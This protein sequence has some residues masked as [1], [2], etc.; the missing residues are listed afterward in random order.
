MS[1][2][3]LCSIVSFTFIKLHFQSFYFCFWSLIVQSFHFTCIECFESAFFK[4]CLNSFVECC[5][6]E[7]FHLLR[8]FNIKY[9]KSN[10]YLIAFFLL[11]LIL[12]LVWF[13]TAARFQHI[14][15]NHLNWIVTSKNL[16]ETIFLIL[17]IERAS[18]N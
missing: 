17:S 7:S 12:K 5:L 1:F 6:S 13:E 14:F 18:V 8:V 3:W 4:A 16:S 9:F 15:K 11:S 10:D 2:D